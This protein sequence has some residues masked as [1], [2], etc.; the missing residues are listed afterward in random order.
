MAS[1]MT[2]VV[3]KDQDISAFGAKWSLFISSLSYTL[4]IAMFFFL[5]TWV[6][7]ALSAL[8]GLGAAVLWT[9]QG[10]YLSMNSNAD[11]IS[12]N[13]AI[14][15]ALFQAANGGGL[16][17]TFL[18][19]GNS[20]VTDS[21]R[22]E[23]FT[24]LL[25]VSAA[26]NIIFLFLPQS[27]LK[28]EGQN[29]PNQ[30][31]IQNKIEIHTEPEDSEADNFVDAD[32]QQLLD[33]NED[34]VGVQNVEAVRGIKDA[35]V[36]SMKLFAQKRMIL[37]FWTFFYTGI[38]TSFNTGIYGTCLGNT[39]YWNNSKNLVGLTTTVVGLGQI[40]ACLFGGM[41]RRL[42]LRGETVFLIGGVVHLLTFL[43]IF[44][45]LPTDSPIER[46][47]EKAYIN[48]NEYIGL[49]CAFLLGFGDG[50]IETEIMNILV[51]KYP[52][53]SAPAFALFKFSQSL[54]CAVAFFYSTYL[55]LNYQIAIVI[56]CNVISSLGFF[57]ASAI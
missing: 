4:F 22:T 49:A 30:S 53:D 11:S 18:F 40:I 41:S 14:F 57:A 13:S 54:A 29:E 9:S 2:T 37:L 33:E 15:W 38:V 12:V 45:N 34:A 16:I 42:K 47:L 19:Q 32:S 52:G 51:T 5:I 1:K 28:S 17:A 7:Y 10:A 56:S 6:F 27:A 39:A 50:C 44:I 23:L 21:Q 46:T 24:I 35:L 26:A 55:N 8:V 3:L 48:P 31:S 20:G 43:L 36:K 25:A